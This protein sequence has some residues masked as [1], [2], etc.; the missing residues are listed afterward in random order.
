MGSVYIIESEN[1]ALKLIPEDKIQ[2]MKIL[3]GV[4]YIEYGNLMYNFGDIL[5][6]IL[7]DEEERIVYTY[8]DVNLCADLFSTLEGVAADIK[9]YEDLVKVYKSAETYFYLNYVTT[10]S[11]D[12][13]MKY[14]EIIEKLLALDPSGDILSSR[15]VET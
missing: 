7:Y 14:N 9:N 15:I 12:I 10:S 5:P 13:L 1:A 4:A 8:S 6:V 11:D 3:A 2:H